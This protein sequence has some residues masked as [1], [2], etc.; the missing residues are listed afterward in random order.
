[1]IDFIV[2]AITIFLSA[3]ISCAQYSIFNA[4]TFDSKN[5]EIKADETSFDK[6]N[7][8]ILAYGNVQ[9]VLKLKTGE[10]VIA[11]GSFAKYN[12]ISEGGEIW[13]EGTSI[14]YYVKGSSIPIT[15]HAK[16]IQF[17]KNEVSIKAH[18]D[19]VVETSSGS[20]RSDN[21]LF[22]QK[23]FSAIFKKDKKRPVAEFWN[24]DQNQ[25]YTADKI[26]FFN[27]NDNKKIFMEGDVKGKIKME[28]TNDTK[29]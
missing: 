21:A 19:V 26:T 12:T 7:S 14:K 24:E 15:M 11:K 6:K 4:E 22:D 18:S 27:N 3:D 13:G 25:T 10:T 9:I 8:E 29:N 20:I 23:T 1:L 2:I 16:K 17:D 28:G 5:I